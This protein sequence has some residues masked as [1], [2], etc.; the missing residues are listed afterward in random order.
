MTAENKIKSK[1]YA[2]EVEKRKALVKRPSKMTTPPVRQFIFYWLCPGKQEPPGFANP[3]FACI[4]NPDA[5]QGLNIISRQTFFEPE[6]G[7]NC[8]IFTIKRAVEPELTPGPSR[9]V[10]TLQ[11][12]DKN[13]RTIAGLPGHKIQQ[14]VLPINQIHINPSAGPE[15]DLGSFGQSLAGM[16]GQ[17]LLTTVGL[18]FSNSV[19]TVFAGV[20]HPYQG[21]AQQVAGNSGCAASKEISRK[22]FPG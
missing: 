13:S 5:W 15:H 22:S 16:A 14:P 17:I 21:F 19:A 20:K 11:S 8:Q 1:N 3:R 6:P 10:K 12:A 7:G 4:V 9:S 2:A 18:C